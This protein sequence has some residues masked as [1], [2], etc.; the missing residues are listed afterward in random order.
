MA[1]LNHDFHLLSLAEYSY[2][3]WR[4]FY[5]R[6]DALLIH[7]DIIIYLNDTL[8]WIICHNPAYKSLPKLEGL[9]L[10]G[11][12]IIKKDGAVVAQRVFRNWTTLFANGPKR[13]R[14]TGGYGWIE[15]KSIEAT[16]KYSVIKADRDD[17]VRKLNILADWSKQVVES[18]G[19]LFILHLGI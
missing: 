7:D 16:G 15:G 12:T 4:K 14:L 3:D 13:L 17:L 8:K 1:G 6:P 2:F 5:H 9:A 10:Y 18:K 11:P 19:K